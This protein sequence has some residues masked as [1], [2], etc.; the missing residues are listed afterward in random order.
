MSLIDIPRHLRLLAVAGPP[1]VDANTC[2][3]K[4]VA[5]EAGGVTAI[6]VRMKELPVNELVH[7]TERLVMQLS[8]PVYV[9]DRADVALASG[10]HGV[11]LGAED[12]SPFH[13]REF[14]PRPFLIGVSV[15]TDEEAESVQDADV[16]YWSLG[17]F[18]I[19]ASKADAGSPLGASG[20]RRLANQA[21]KNMPILAIGGIDSSNVAEV[22]QAGADGIAVIGAIFGTDDVEANAKRLR[23]IIDEAR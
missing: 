23:T 1:F 21:P 22:L 12:V 3:E 16:D 17:S 4:C 8:I 19:T 2:V 9:N 6:Q 5:A 15:G 14:A 7:L 20:F 11:H 13:V 10:A 18:F